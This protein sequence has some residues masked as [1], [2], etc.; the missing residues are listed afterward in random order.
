MHIDLYVGTRH[1]C[2]ILIKF[3]FLERREKSSQILSFMS[4]RP[5]G[6]EVFYTGEQTDRRG[7]HNSRF[8]HCC[9]S[10]YK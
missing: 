3:T 2:Q 1:S 8:S 10:T 4:I 7:K 9:K 5:V 6:S